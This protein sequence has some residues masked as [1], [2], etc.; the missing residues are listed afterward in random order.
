MDFAFLLSYGAL[1]ILV[2]VQTLVLLGLV[3][4][5]H[6]LTQGRSSVAMLAEEQSRMI[7]EMLPAFQVVDHRGT[8]IDSAEFR[9]KNTVLL[10]VSPSCQG[11]VRALDDLAPFS[12]RGD[13]IVLCRGDSSECE[14]LTARH[15]LKVPVGLDVDSRV[16]AMLHINGVPTAVVVDREGRIRSYG[17][18]P[19]LG[20]E[21]EAVAAIE[22]REAS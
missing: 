3:A 12:R 7:G 15:S 21:T 9:G 11:C 5:V 17:S 1:W 13:V 19:D 22:S 16:S 14:Q 18:S 4:A 2:A 20:L 10:F 8:R 6:R